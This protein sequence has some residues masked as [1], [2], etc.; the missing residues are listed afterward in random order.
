MEENKELSPL[1]LPPIKLFD[2]YF[3]PKDDTPF[4]VDSNSLDEIIEKI[5]TILDAFIV[6][7]EMKGDD[8]PSEIFEGIIS[9]YSPELSN[10]DTSSEFWNKGRSESVYKKRRDKYLE[11]LSLLFKIK[12][13]FVYGI[14]SII[15]SQTDNYSFVDTD[16]SEFSEFIKIDRDVEIHNGISNVKKYVLLKWISSYMELFESHKKTTIVHSH[17]FQMYYRSRTL[18]DFVEISYTLVNQKIDSKIEEYKKYVGFSYFA[19]DKTSH[20]NLEKKLQPITESIE[21]ISPAFPEIKAKYIERKK[22]SCL[23]GMKFL[24][25]QYAAIS[26]I[27]MNGEDEL[28]DTLWERYGIELIKISPYVRYYYTSSRYITYE[29]FIDWRNR[30]SCDDSYLRMFSCCERKLLTVCY[31]SN[32]CKNQDCLIYVTL[33]PCQ[34]CVRAIN[35]VDEELGL[36]VKIRCSKAVS[37]ADKIIEEKYLDLAKKIIRDKISA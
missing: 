22:K 4:D 35:K 17:L 32:K 15:K 33:T 3:N 24:K 1:H 34:M 13:L 28:G 25:R 9:R 16:N 27:S 37:K 10:I 6:S 7:L 2:I 5:G 36:K 11:N 20:E 14:N 26:G 12:T 8:N 23:A 30:Y 29:D 19:I 18:P 21:L 31:E